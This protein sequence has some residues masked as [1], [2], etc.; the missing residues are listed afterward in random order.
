MPDQF[1]TI[2]PKKDRIFLATTDS[3]V[4]A[5]FPETRVELARQIKLLTLLGYEVVFGAPFVWQSQYTQA[6]IQDL[7][8]LVEAKSLGVMGRER[9]ET[10]SEYL[11]ERQEDTSKLPVSILPTNSIFATEV[12]T[13]NSIVLAKNLDSL[14]SLIPRQGSV[15]ANFANLYLQDLSYMANLPI[16]L[17]SQ[18]RTILPT[19]F[20]L[21]ARSKAEILTIILQDLPGKGHFSRAAIYISAVSNSIPPD[22]VKNINLRSTT[23]YHAANAIACSSTLFTWANIA[24]SVPANIKYAH[25]Y[26]IAPENPYLFQ[27]TLKIF[28]ISPQVIDN[29]PLETIIRLSTEEPE[30]DAFVKWYKKFISACEVSGGNYSLTTSDAKPLLRRISK[31]REQTISSEINRDIIV[32]EEKTNLSWYVGALQALVTL[33]F[34]PSAFASIPTFFTAKRYTEAALRILR[35]QCEKSISKPLGDFEALIIREGLRDIEPVKYDGEIP[36][37]HKPDSNISLDDLIRPFF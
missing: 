12:P 21:S 34:G 2:S 13:A 24:V 15:E 6:A 35:N 30:V 20:S 7:A 25:Q 28:G 22:L 36:N 33:H 3:V 8:P 11:K 16:S 10:A 19:N 14:S 17:D 18:I 9:V 32:K 26:S 29:I 1:I 31:Q 27:E 5:W 23:L 4:Q 37:Y